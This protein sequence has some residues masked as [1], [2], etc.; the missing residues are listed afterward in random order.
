MNLLAIGCGQGGKPTP[1]VVCAL[2][3]IFCAGALRWLIQ[4]SF[5]VLTAHRVAL[6]AAVNG[7][8]QG[9]WLTQRLVVGP[10]GNARVAV[11]VALFLLGMVINIDSDVRLANL[12]PPG[13]V[14][15]L[16]CLL[17]WCALVLLTAGGLDADRLLHPSRWRL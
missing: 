5:T 12:R 15:A 13:A 14:S 2:A 3:F 11:G 10:F 8:L 7:Y 6:P 9:R 4:L 17:A 16:A 1:V